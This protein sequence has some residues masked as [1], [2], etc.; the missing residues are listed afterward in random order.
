MSE[1]QAP[2]NPPGAASQQPATQS[3]GLVPFQQLDS[4]LAATFQQLRVKPSLYDLSI[5]EG[6]SSENLLQLAKAVARVEEVPQWWW[7]SL[8]NY[9]GFAHGERKT[10]T[11][12]PEW[13]GPSYEEWEHQG[14]AHG[15]YLEWLQSGQVIHN[16]GKLFTQKGARARLLARSYFVKALLAP[17]EKRI[18]LLQR[19][20]SG[21]IGSVRELEAEISRLKDS[22]PVPTPKSASK[23]KKGATT[24]VEAQGETDQKTKLPTDGGGYGR[25]MRQQPIDRE[26]IRKC[27]SEKIRQALDQDKSP[28]FRSPDDCRLCA[29]VTLDPWV[30]RIAELVIFKGLTPAQARA[31]AEK[32]YTLDPDQIGRSLRIKLTGFLSDALNKGSWSP[33]WVGEV[34]HPI[35]NMVTDCELKDL[36]RLINFDP[37]SKQELNEVSLQEAAYEVITRFEQGARSIAE[38]LVFRSEQPKEAGVPNSAQVQSSSQA[39]APD[40]DKEPLSEKGQKA[41][42][43][44]IAVLRNNIAD[45]QEY[46]SKYSERD[47]I[48]WAKPESVLRTRQIRRCQNGIESLQQIIKKVD[49]KRTTALNIDDM[50]AWK[51]NMS[52]PEVFY[53]KDSRGLLFTVRIE[54]P[55]GVPSE[56][57]ERDKD[58]FLPIKEAIRR[59]SREHGHPVNAAAPEPE[60][61]PS[62]AEADIPFEGSIL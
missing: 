37:K 56:L 39:P 47:L 35:W 14:R 27:A 7:G 9:S 34:K 33:N 51:S 1:L 50:A 40:K 8:W 28:W 55:T 45:P 23:G 61:I 38:V 18:A 11:E 5:P 42:K 25:N 19:C 60:A 2:S 49:E 12:D 31:Q 20:A 59:Y 52:G 16:T 30:R 15:L 48:D 46:F 17:P 36:L 54:S 57:R 29:E 21:E 41:L 6:L 58:R 26:R 24:D 32:E 22:I 53:I 62:E 10:L 13:A 4:Q 3:S 43:Q 44:L